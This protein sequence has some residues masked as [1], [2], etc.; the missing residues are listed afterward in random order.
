MQKIIAEVADV[1]I[2]SAIT[3]IT[4]LEAQFKQNADIQKYGPQALSVLQT[5]Q[6]VVSSI[7]SQP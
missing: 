7:A 5:L 3:A 1:V 2:A 6:T 4:H